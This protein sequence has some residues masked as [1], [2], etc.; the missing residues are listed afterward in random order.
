[1]LTAISTVPVQLDLT[2]PVKIQKRVVNTLRALN[3]TRNDKASWE[4]ALADC[5]VDAGLSRDVPTSL[6]SRP[7]KITARGSIPVSAL[8]EQQDAIEKLHREFVMGCLTQLIA[9]R[10]VLDTEL[11]AK[12]A[13]VRAD[14]ERDVSSRDSRLERVEPLGLLHGARS[15]DLLRL[16]QQ[17]LLAADPRAAPELAHHQL[18]RLEPET[19]R[20]RRERGLDTPPGAIRRGRVWPA[21]GR[22]REHLRERFPCDVRPREFSFVLSTLR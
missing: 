2:A 4:A 9:S 18:A 11:R 16:L 21:A 17:P 19:L 14:V 8:Q 22:G 20:H 7:P 3:T 5:S 13:A 10:D 1:M 15:Q 12:Q 6:R